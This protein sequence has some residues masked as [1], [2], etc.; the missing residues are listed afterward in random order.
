M[1][2]IWKD[3]HRNFSRDANVRWRGIEGRTTHQGEWDGWCTCGTGTKKFYGR[4]HNKSVRNAF[5][6]ELP[7]LLEDAHWE[8]VEQWE[9]LDALLLKEFEEFYQYTGSC[10]DDEEVEDLFDDSDYWGLEDIFW[11]EEDELASNY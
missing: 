11:D 4:E 7:E 5:K 8:L 1:R 10:Y 6:A 3:G 9:E 2:G